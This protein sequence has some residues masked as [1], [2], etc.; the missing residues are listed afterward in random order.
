MECQSLLAANSPTEE[1]SRGGLTDGEI[2]T[3]ADDETGAEGTPTWVIV[4]AIA[5]MVLI[6]I[7]ACG[8][9]AWW[10]RFKRLRRWGG[11]NSAGVDDFC[12]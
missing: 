9:C 5:V 4:T 2:Y 8:A 6:A 11:V 1:P 7:V 12:S 3:S 10:K